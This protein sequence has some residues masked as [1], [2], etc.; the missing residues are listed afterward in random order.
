[1]TRKLNSSDSNESYDSYLLHTFPIPSTFT[2]PNKTLNV[3]VCEFHISCTYM[4]QTIEWK[5][6]SLCLISDNALITYLHIFL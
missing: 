5:Y 2:P 1:M 6:I 3:C 4:V